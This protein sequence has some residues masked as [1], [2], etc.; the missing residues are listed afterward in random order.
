MCESRLCRGIG[1]AGRP[2]LPVRG[3]EG[4]EGELSVGGLLLARC[5]VF[6]FTF[7]LTLNIHAKESNK[8]CNL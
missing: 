7:P 8:V 3:E 6:R 1:L 5:R 2:H 4:E